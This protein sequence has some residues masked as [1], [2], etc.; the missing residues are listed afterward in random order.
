MKTTTNNTQTQT[1]N[2]A[3]GFKKFREDKFKKRNS[4]DA[5]M[6]ELG[7]GKTWEKSNGK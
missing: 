4:F 2:K 7:V 6:L 1:A 5:A 3:G